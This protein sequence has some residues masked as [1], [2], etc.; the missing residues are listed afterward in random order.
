MLLLILIVLLALPVLLGVVPGLDARTAVR[1][2]A[3]C[4]A[5]GV[6][7]GA[8]LVMLLGAGEAPMPGPAAAMPW[9]VGG[10]LAGTV[11]GL[12]SIALR[13]LLR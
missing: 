3:R 2:V 11:L 13:R 4:A 6:I 5:A 12:M 8:V 10:A 9:L 7:V 1:H